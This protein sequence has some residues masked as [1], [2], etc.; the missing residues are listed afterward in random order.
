VYAAHERINGESGEVYRFVGLYA[1][2]ESAMTTVGELGAVKEL[3]PD[4][5]A[6]NDLSATLIGAIQSLDA[7]AVRQWLKACPRGEGFSAALAL[8]VVLRDLDTVRVLLAHGADPV[9]RDEHGDTVLHRALEH[10][11]DE[12][13]REII[14]A[15]AET[16]N[17]LNIADNLGRTPLHLAITAGDLSLVD[18]FIAL[19]A[20]ISLK[21][22]NGEGPVLLALR[23]REGRI[24]EL[25][26]ASGAE[27]DLLSSCAAGDCGAVARA[28]RTEPSL[29]S[30]TLADGTSPLHLAAAFGDVALSQLLMD[31]GANVDAVDSNGETPLLAARENTVAGV[32]ISAGADVNVANNDGETPLFHACDAERA[33]MLL[34]AGANIDHRDS[35]DATA[36]H[37]AAGYHRHDDVV[38][39]LLRHGAQADAVDKNGD[40]PLRWAAEAEG[41]TMST[42]ERQ[43]LLAV[44]RILLAHKADPS[45][46][47]KPIHVCHSSGQVDFAF[48]AGEVKSLLLEAGYGDSDIR[49]IFD[50]HARWRP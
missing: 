39:C 17:A 43:R 23:A 50:Q 25:L 45:A 20:D 5:L 28:L 3:V 13:V 49:G 7:E 14:V 18:R 32:L 30:T 26:V 46:L 47:L 41:G 2:F 34:E 1:T 12:T 6:N 48:S 19:G 31:H 40:T 29:V 44:V 33:E 42:A 22:R 36:V 4:K 21:T 11:G 16:G 37:F 15:L 24:A 10:S 8:A 9:L 35:L 38:K 27:A